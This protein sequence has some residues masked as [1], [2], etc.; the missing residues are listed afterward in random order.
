MLAE[1][2]ALLITADQVVVAMGGTILEKPESEEEARRFIASYADDPPRT[3]GSCVVTDARS[4]QQWS[5]VDEACVHFRPIPAATVDALVAEGEIF[6]CAGGL[7]TS[8]VNSSKTCL[9]R[10]A[11]GAVAHS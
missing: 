3:V 11:C 6:Y 2:G 4:G 1:R 8:P 7:S 9:I 10:P 5:F